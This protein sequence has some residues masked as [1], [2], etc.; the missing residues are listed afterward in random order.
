MEN[1]PA[2][3]AGI[4]IFIPIFLK[5][6]CCS[7]LVADSRLPRFTMLSA[8]GTLTMATMMP[9]AIAGSHWP[10]ATTMPSANQKHPVGM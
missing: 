10:N 5:F 9:L 4:K 8:A 2:P 7:S 6:F 3:N 1:T